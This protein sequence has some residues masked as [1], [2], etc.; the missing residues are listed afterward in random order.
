MNGPLPLI[1][2]SHKR[3]RTWLNKTNAQLIVELGEEEWKENKLNTQHA[4][5]FTGTHT[6]SI[7]RD[8]SITYRYVN[9]IGG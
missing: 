5:L 3:H 1:L 4:K 2:L 9:L 7:E 6:K 8:A